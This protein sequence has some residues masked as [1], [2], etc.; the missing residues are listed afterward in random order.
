[1]V[2]VLTEEW[3]DSVG[4]YF[5]HAWTFKPTKSQLLEHTDGRNLD[6]VLMGGGRIGVE[7]RWYNLREIHNEI[8]T[9]S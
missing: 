1:M 6:W 7:Y 9:T 3:N 8:K 5:V 2:W 4:E